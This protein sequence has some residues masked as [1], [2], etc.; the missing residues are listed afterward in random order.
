MKHTARLIICL[1]LCTLVIAALPVSGEEEIYH[2]VIRL[3]IIAASD[4]ERDQSL[5]LLVRDAVLEKYGSALTSC[6]TRDDA[7]A[8]LEPLLPAVETLARETLIQAGCDAPVAVTLGEET[9]PTRDYETFSLPAGKYL[10]LRILIGDAAGHNWWCVL[11]P[12]LCLDTALE[13]SP[14]LS[15]AEYGL[16][17]E[18][19]QGKYSVKFKVLE[20]LEEL[21]SQ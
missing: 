4:S 13:E 12:P 7:R 19:N 10:S 20:L 3:H 8:A 18:N 15:D 14:Q 5:K 16:L 1:L 2:D 17:R 11:Y 6:P 9:Y 21:F